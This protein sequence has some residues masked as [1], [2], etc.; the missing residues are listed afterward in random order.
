MSD[1]D[2]VHE[3]VIVPDL[4]RDALARCRRLR[5]QWPD[6]A[7]FASV[8]RQLDY[9]LKVATDPVADRSRLTDI[10]I[11]VQAAREVETIDPDL[12][13][14]LHTINAWANAWAERLA[15]LK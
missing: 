3:G 11:G 6:I 9:L 14:L 12:A 5:E 10:V 2:D 15:T 7:T 8:H 13:D 4:I 1:D